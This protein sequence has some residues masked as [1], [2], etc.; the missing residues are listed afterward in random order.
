MAVVGP[1]EA[2]AGQ[3]QLTDVATGFTGR[4]QQRALVAAVQRAHA[5]RAARVDWA[6]ESVSQE[7]P[8]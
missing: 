8:A 7:P 4:L 5:A 1:I 6:G 3:V 2:A